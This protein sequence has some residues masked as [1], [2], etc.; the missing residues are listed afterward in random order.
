MVKVRAE[1]PATA[2]ELQELPGGLVQLLDKPAE[3]VIVGVHVQHCDIENLLDVH[4]L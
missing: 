3:H 2:Q 4:G 1:E